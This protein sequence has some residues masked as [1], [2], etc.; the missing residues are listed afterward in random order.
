MSIERQKI[1]NVFEVEQEFELPPDTAVLFDYYTHPNA[2]G[3]GLYQ[4][5]LLQGLHDA[6]NVPGTRKVFMGVMSDNTPSRHVVEKLG[7]QYE[8]S[9]FKMTKFGR[10]KK[11]QTRTETSVAG[12]NKLRLEE[13]FSA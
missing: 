1:S 11:W 9:L 8:G 3:K 6:A 2:R 4:Q 5:S 10:S 12:L 7:F 13:N